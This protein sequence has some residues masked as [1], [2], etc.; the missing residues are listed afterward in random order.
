MMLANNTNLPELPFWQAR[1]FWAQLL[2]VASVLANAAGFDLFGALREMG[3]GSNPD[4]VMATVTRIGSA[5]QVLAPAFFGVWAW[6][7]RRAPNFRLVFW[8]SP[9]ELRMLAFWG[10]LLFLA[11]LAVAAAP[12]AARAEPRCMG[13]ADA[14]ADLKARFGEDLRWSGLTTSGQL[15]AITLAPDGTTWTAL[16]ILPDGKACLIAA[17]D[18]WAEKTAQAPGEDG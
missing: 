7:E 3:I 14:L 5:L 9:P 18:S 16:A 8:R 10:P 17:G 15:L 12:L 6:L 13:Q 4:E 11:A 2:L 1:S